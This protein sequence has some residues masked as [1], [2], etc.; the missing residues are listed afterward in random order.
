MRTF[1]CL[2]LVAALAA[3]CGGAGEAAPAPTETA[4]ADQIEPAPVT[5]AAGTPAPVT[6]GPEY[7]V[8]L[9]ALDHTLAGTRYAATVFEDPE[10]A[11]ATGLLLCERLAAGLAPGEAALEYV[12]ELAGDPAAATDDDLVLA[13]ALVG[14]AGEALCPEASR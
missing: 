4:D 1:A 3:G 14:A 10:L 12:G 13:G 7:D 9:A 8:Y 5:T 11:A 2:A 6:D